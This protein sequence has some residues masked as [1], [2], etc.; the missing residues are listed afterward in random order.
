MRSLDFVWHRYVCSHTI[1][2]PFSS[3]VS[4]WLCFPFLLESTQECFHLLARK[5]L[6]LDNLWE[7]TGKVTVPGESPLWGRDQEPISS[8]TGRPG[9]CYKM[10]TA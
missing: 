9:K 2:F 4:F 6:I 8:V 7:A 3:T 1:L 10:G 5:C